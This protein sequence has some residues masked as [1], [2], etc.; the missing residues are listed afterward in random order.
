MVRGLSQEST[1]RADPQRTSGVDLESMQP[2]TL[3]NPA[4]IADAYWALYQ[5]PRDAWTFERV[6]RPW[7]EKW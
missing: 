7:A 1:S 3:M 4:S 5:Q 6:V 2:D